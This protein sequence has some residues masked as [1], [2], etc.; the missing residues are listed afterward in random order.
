[1]LEGRLG[2]QMFRRMFGAVLT[3]NGSEFSNPAA[4]ETD[5]EGGRRTRMFHCDPCSA[6]QKPCVENNHRNLRKVLRKGVSFD[7]LTQEQVNR[8]MSH[9]NSLLRKEYGDKSAV[10]RFRDVFGKKALT[11]LGI[12][13]I[14]PADVCL[15]PSLVGLPE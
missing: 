6:W 4:L 13:E 9:V 10:S 11:A 3:D 12:D 14:P 15:K 8:V 5:A 1:M 2:P 7:S